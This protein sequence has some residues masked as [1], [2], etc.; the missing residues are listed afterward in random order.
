MTPSTMNVLKPLTP[1]SG[2]YDLSDDDDESL[3][4]VLN[5]LPSVYDDVKND[6]N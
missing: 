5:P 2:W 4:V 3:S 6:D 1:P